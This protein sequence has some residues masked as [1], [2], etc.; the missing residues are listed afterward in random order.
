[1]VS[2]SVFLA[3]RMNCIGIVCHSAFIG[4]NTLT[5]CHLSNICI[6]HD[7]N[8]EQCNCVLHFVKLNIRELYTVS[9]FINGMGPRLVMAFLHFVEGWSMTCHP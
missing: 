6:K 9:T 7:C 3:C 5:Q 2:D 1:M 8:N 4:L